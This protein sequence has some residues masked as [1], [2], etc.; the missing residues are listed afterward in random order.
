MA[1]VQISRIQIRR[2]KANSGTGFP[3]LASGELGWAVDTQQLFIGNGSVAEGAPTTGNTKVITQLDLTGSGNILNLIQ[4][5][6][7]ATDPSMITGVSANTPVARYL[8]DRL[9]DHVS[10]K[11]FGAVGDGVTDDTGAIQR[12]I[13]E[14]YLNPVN[15]A[16]GSVPDAVRRR[17][18]L[19]FPAGT[20]I[21]SNTL[22]VPSFATLAGQGQDKSVILYNSALS[23]SVTPTATSFTAYPVVSAAAVSHNATTGIQGVAQIVVDNASGI[24]VGMNVIGG[25]IGSGA[26]VTN[27]TGTTISLSATNTGTVTGSV[28]FGT[29]AINVNSTVGISAG[30]GVFGTG[31]SAGTTVSSIVG[32][33]VVLNQA[34]A[35]GSLASI[36]T[37]ANIFPT[38]SSY[39]LSTY[40]TAGTSIGGSVLT[41]NSTNGLY[42]GINVSG[43]GI[44]SGTTITS[45]GASNNTIVLS[46]IIPSNTITVTNTTTSSNLVT[47]TGTTNYSGYSIASVGYIGTP[48]NYNFITLNKTITA[49]AGTPVT[50]DAITGST[51]LAANTTYYVASSVSNS[52]TVTLSATLNGPVISNLTTGTP[53]GTTSLTI[54]NSFLVSGLPIVLGTSIGNLIAGNT[55]YVSTVYSQTTFTVSASLG[56]TVFALTTAS[57]GGTIMA[58]TGGIPSGET[59]SFGGSTGTAI[60]VSATTGII[61]GMSVSGSGISAGTTV[62]SIN[63]TTI[64]INNPL[65]SSPSGS[66]IFGANAVTLSSSLSVFVGETVSGTGIANGATIT[67]INGTVATLSVNNTAAV[68]GTLNIAISVSEPIMQFVNDT[69]TPGFPSILSSSTSTNQPRRI[70]IR[71]LTLQTINANQA[72]LQLDACKESNFDQCRI[73]GNWGGVYNINSAGIVLNAFSSLVT[74]EFNQFDNVTVTGFSAGIYS[75][76]DISGN[77]FTNSYYYN[78]RQGFVLGTTSNGATT[79]QVYGPRTTIIQNCRFNNIKQQAMIVGLGSGNTISNCRLINVGN[80]GGGNGTAQYPQVYLTNFGNSAD[81]NYSD[82]PDDL[83]TPTTFSAIP[84]Y[85]EVAGI[86]TYK[87]YATRQI[88]LGQASSYASAFRLPVN[89]TSTGSPVNDIAYEVFYIYRSALNYTRQGV[90]RITADITNSVIQVS[91]EYNFAGSDSTPGLIAAS[92]KSSSLDF[93]AIFLAG[94]G[95]VYTSAPQVASMIQVQYVNPLSGDGGAFTFSYSATF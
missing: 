34:L 20:Y 87:S 25:N 57:A 21:T 12:A 95:S 36:L 17:V 91:D 66:G 15:K 1:V 19:E 69:S 10:V 86:G 9:D 82:R 81:N 52:I 90:L 18:T 89:T 74:C 49:S 8:Q 32:S 33:Q 93:Q 26:L 78:L 94:D 5:I 65:S 22:Y 80:N 13:N 44:T 47:A 39:S 61:P 92:T 59:I 37:F 11:D 45:I 14:L 83:S 58:T 29:N 28:Q 84:Y 71:Y 43:V 79:G 76:N 60:T 38:I 40:T 73:V 48:S 77:R 54:G 51:G 46:T 2:G 41:L 42:V 27:V 56:G 23:T 3:Q 55:Y 50:T 30:Q 75:Q 67:S 6:Y 7:K 85:P 68:T 31:V 53:T 88:T 63:G 35:G 24:I 16:S 4:H 64:I 72:G 70:N 62:T